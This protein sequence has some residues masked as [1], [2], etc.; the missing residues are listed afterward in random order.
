MRA[1][2]RRLSRSSVGDGGDGVHA[3][4]EELVAPTRG[5]DGAIGR[6]RDDVAALAF[7]LDERLPVVALVLLLLRSLGAL[8]EFAGA[9]WVGRAEE[10]V[11]AAGR[12]SL[13]V[14]TR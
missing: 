4:A 5:M 10:D 3:A 13:Q 12:G 14:A 11:I 9:G 8:G 1:T 7:G 2:A 6:C